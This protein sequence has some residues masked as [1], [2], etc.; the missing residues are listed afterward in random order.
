M[1][2]SSTARIGLLLALSAGISWAQIW[3]GDG[4]TG[5]KI[6]F[7]RDVRPILADKCFACHGPDGGARKAGLRLDRREN[8]IGDLGGYAAIVPGDLEESELAYRIRADEDDRMPPSD[9]RKSLSE[10][11][12]H[13]LERWIEEGAVYEKHWALIAPERPETPGL[14]DS[15][16]AGQVDAFIQEKLDQNGLRP[17][18]EADRTTLLRRL[19]FDLTGLPPTPG[20]IDAFLRDFAPDAW[21]KQV[22][23][24]MASPHFGERM[25]MGWLDLVRF[26]DTVGYHGDQVQN[27]I[28]YRDWV[29]EAFN[30]N[31]PFDQFTR[32][33]LA[34]DLVEG[35]GDDG[36][37]ASCYNRLLQTSHEGGVQLKEY[38]AIYDADRVRNLGSAWLGMTVGCAQCHD[39][40]FD[41]IRQREFYQ[42][43]AFFA[44]I[45]EHG[46]LKDGCCNTNPTRRL[47]EMD[48]FSPMDRREMARLEIALEA[49]EDGDKARATLEGI[50]EDFKPRRVM[51]SKAI[52]PRTIRVLARGD[53]MDESGEIVQPDVPAALPPLSKK[54]ERATRLDLAD[55]L[56]TPEHPLTARVFVNRIWRQF[57]GRGLSKSLDDFGS[58]GTWPDHP[59]LLDWL[60]VEF[61]ESG[62]DVKGLIRLLVTSNAYRRTSTPTAGELEDDPE[63]QWFGRQNRWRLEAELIRDQVLSLAGLLSPKV[64]GA[65][66]HPYQPVGYYEHLNFPKRKYEADH[67]EQ[68]YRR[69]LYT[70][71]Q[72]TFLHPAML[73]FDAPTREE[74]AAE[75]A[76]SNTPSAA[77]A[78]LNDPTILEA[79]RAFAQRILLEGGPADRARISWAFRSAVG[80]SP[81]KAE[82]RLLGD[83]LESHKRDYL[84]EP[85]SAEKLLVVGDFIND[86]DLNRIELAA[87]TSVARALL[88]LHETINRF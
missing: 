28:P 7:N 18:G 86:P 81:E 85:E 35:A 34:G 61:R 6:S 70:H 62:W 38:A 83:L 72:R 54:K 2:P 87:W 64:G 23:R 60:A 26:A 78:L 71:W 12:K 68:Q 52:E 63:N 22:D 9:Y 10:K 84:Q 16:V 41:P 69:G 80:R 24:L 21:E 14:S 51:V 55:W 50:K 44:D 49:L 40:K 5:E 48:I 32:L 65:S 15:S 46:H 67:G 3:A 17:G 1:T 42:L 56:T 30:R 58:Q 31:M 59:E 25:A 45:E 57:F 33:Q 47:P 75:R 39:H 76:I 73:A 8:A 66:G 88:N 74:C 4:G 13:A 43:V 20:E 27:V 82:A 11:E 29:I 77:L 19:A 79:S 37:I 53:W 36:L